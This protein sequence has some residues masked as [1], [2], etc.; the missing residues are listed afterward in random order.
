MRLVLAAACVVAAFVLSAA[1]AADAPSFVEYQGVHVELART[2]ADFDAYAADPD[3]LSPARARQVES[4]MREARVGPR[5]ESD[6]ALTQ[7][8]FKLRFPG[9]GFFEAN[10][11]GAHLDPKLELVSLEIPKRGLNRYIALEKQPDGSLVVV[12]DFVAAAQPEITRV[13][14]KADGKL[15]YRAT[16]GRVAAPARR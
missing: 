11:L 3:N 2:Y 9:Y 4:L 5:F 6:E 8:L 10:Q 15:E 12:D 13:S 16:G 7:A 1:R 14:R